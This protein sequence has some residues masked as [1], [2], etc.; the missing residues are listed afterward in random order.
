M[1]TTIGTYHS[2]YMTVCYSGW[3]YRTR[4]T[5]SWFFSTQAFGYILSQI[6]IGL[7]VK[8]QLFLSDL[9]KLELSWQIFEK[10]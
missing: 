1:Y 5:E 4:I 7:H 9:M 6:Y 10:C 8:Y 3:I 2:F